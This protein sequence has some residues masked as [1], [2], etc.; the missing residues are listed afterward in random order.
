M[1]V[2]HALDSH[3]K[4]H[5]G[6]MLSRQLELALRLDQASAE[7]CRGVMADAVTEL[8]EGGHSFKSI[9]SLVTDANKPGPI[10]D[11]NP[12]PHPSLGGFLGQ[13]DA[14]EDPSVFVAGIICK[15]VKRSLV[16]LFSPSNPDHSSAEILAK[17]KFISSCLQEEDDTVNPA[18]DNLWLQVQN[19]IDGLDA[20]SY[21]DERSATVS[22][23]LDLQS[24]L[25]EIWPGWRPPASH[26]GVEQDA[27]RGDAAAL[28]LGRTRLTLRSHWPHL[29]LTASEVST[30]EAGTN[31]FSTLVTSPLTLD[32]AE[33]LQELLAETWAEGRVWKSSE[34]DEGL[35]GS[36]SSLHEL[37]RDLALSSV[38][39]DLP[40]F[41]IKLVDRLRHQ[42]STRLQSSLSLEDIVALTKASEGR[43]MI[44]TCVSL[45]S[46]YPQSLSLALD[47]QLAFHSE[48]QLLPLLCAVLVLPFC[49][50]QSPDPAPLHW[51]THCNL[52]GS[53]L[54]SME[55]L[56]IGPSSDSDPLGCL[57]PALASALVLSGDF[58]H[59]AQLT[60]QRLR[61]HPSLAT[62]TGGLSLLR[63]TLNDILDGLLAARG[64]SFRSLS[65][66]RSGQ[67]HLLLSTVPHALDSIQAGLRDLLTSALD[68][69]N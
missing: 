19:T 40:L 64:D 36:C 56:P 14:A 21:S 11:P 66:T 20:S 12:T 42:A 6:L 25:P 32:M 53:I 63:K 22:C 18:R 8:A 51:L 30:R 26:G 48:T 29:T 35:N 15:A 17:L 65:A 69:F 28:I 68:Q 16:E 67:G 54:K 9:R 49:Q 58:S 55:Q 50:G 60:S 41:A 38:S 43:P 44:H 1:R 61:L 3:V 13:T 37:W 59:A 57:F 4:S 24:L 47:P 62:L 34:M 33:R 5:A 31:L 52:W 10:F 46:P 2:W 7:M 45:L 23:L 27:P 39:S